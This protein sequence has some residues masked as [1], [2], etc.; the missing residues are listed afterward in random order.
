MPRGAASVLGRL[1]GAGGE[2]GVVGGV[3][4]VGAGVPFVGDVEHEE[5]GVEVVGAGGE[6]GGVVE[7][8]GAGGGDLEGV[9]GPVEAFEFHAVVVVGVVGGGVAGGAEG[10]EGG[11]L[12]EGG[13][14]GGGGEVGG[15]AAGEGEFFGV[16]GAEDLEGEFGWGFVDVEGA[17]VEDS[18]EDAAA[19][20]VVEPGGGVAA[21][22]VDAF[23][24]VAVLG[25]FD[26]EAV[27]GV[28]GGDAQPR[29]DA[30]RAKGAEAGH[31]DAADGVAVVTLGAER[32]GELAL[33]DGGV[34]AVVEKDAAGDEA[35]DGVEEGHGEGG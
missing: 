28:F 29:G 10:E 11:G 32:G 2:G 26:G 19:E 6:A 9:E 16:V 18:G 7:E 12:V 25:P 14:D 4:E 21:G 17:A 1:G 24:G 13:E 31:A 30:A 15:E 8:A 34:H 20:A 22:D 5:G 3:V 35:V 27:G 23:A 33:E